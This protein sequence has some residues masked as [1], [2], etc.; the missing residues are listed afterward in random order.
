M[1][2][3]VQLPK[4]DDRGE[5]Q[6]G[7]HG[8]AHQRERSDED[9]HKEIGAAPLKEPIRILAFLMALLSTFVGFRSAVAILAD[10]MHIERALMTDEVPE[11]AVEEFT[12]R[13]KPTWKTLLPSCVGIASLL[14]FVCVAGTIAAAYIR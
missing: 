9:R 10:R 11:A 4:H 12:V 1:A 3:S 8:I 13:Q 6:C 14:C 2:V 5:G 7:G